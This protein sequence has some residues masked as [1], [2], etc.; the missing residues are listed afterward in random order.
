[1]SIRTNDL[2][3]AIL[4]ILNENHVLEK[5][6]VYLN[7]IKTNLKTEK[8]KK[9]KI[10]FEEGTFPRGVF[11]LISGKVKIFRNGDEGKAQ[12]IHFAKK[13]E[14]IGFRAVYSE[15]F[16]NVSAETLEDSEICYLTKNQ[17]VSI[18]DSNPKFKNEL[19]KEIS[20]ELT[21]RAEFI[22]KMAQKT[23]KERLAY[24]IILLTEIYD[25]EPINLSRED[26][27]NFVGTAT[28]TLIRLIK[29]FEHIDLIKLE[30]RK[31]SV[32]D[33]KKL[34]KLAGV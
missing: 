19:I 12:I 24:A 23:V 15:E 5:T 13:G 28:E 1:M 32:L 8:Y 3:T 10:L 22:T 33:I 4:D 9:K 14:I 2:F 16:Y 30:A 7:Q 21:V 17:F 18:V 27:A 26:M 31:I 29:E 11:C 20:K 34:Q 6:D 25:K